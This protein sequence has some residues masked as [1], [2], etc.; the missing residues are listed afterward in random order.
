MSAHAGT[1]NTVSVITAREQQAELQPVTVTSGRA[2]FFRA[3]RQIT[4]HSDTPWPRR[5][6]VVEPDHVEHAGADDAQQQRAVKVLRVAV[7]RITAA[8][9][10]SRTRAAAATARRTTRSA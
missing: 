2:A 10:S 7:G 6:H 4:S 3:C 9:D 1:A 5:P 8:H